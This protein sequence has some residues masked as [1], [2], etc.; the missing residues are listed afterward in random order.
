M[1]AIKRGLVIYFD[2]IIKTEKFRLLIS[3]SKNLMGRNSYYKPNL[4]F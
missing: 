1:F 3:A 4:C 2:V